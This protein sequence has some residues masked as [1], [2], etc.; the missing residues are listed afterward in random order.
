MKACVHR[1]TSGCDQVTL[2]IVSNKLHRLS[3]KL[4]DQCPQIYCE[5][6][7]ARSCIVNLQRSLQ[8]EN[9]SI[10]GSIAAAKQCIYQHAGYCDPSVGESLLREIPLLIGND[11]YLCE[12]TLPSCLQNFMMTAYQITNYMPMTNMS[13]DYVLTQMCNEATAAFYCINTHMTSFEGQRLD[14]MNSTQQQIG[15]IVYGK[16]QGPQLQCYS[17][18]NATSNEDCNQQRVQTCSP[19]MQMCGT[20]FTGTVLNK[21]CVKPDL[22]QNGCN[23]VLCSMCCGTSLC[24]QPW[25]DV[26]LESPTCQPEAAMYCG[27]QMISSLVQNETINCLHLQ[28]H[29]SCMIQSTQDCTSSQNMA[30]GIHA[31]DLLARDVMSTCLES[32]PV[33]GCGQ[34]SSMLLL[35][36]VA[37]PFGNVDGFCKTVL[38][39]YERTLK[40]MDLTNCSTG[41]IQSTA[42]NVQM[43]AYMI[44]GICY[45]D[46]IDNRTCNHGYMV[47]SH[48]ETFMADDGC[49]YCTCDRGN[50][51]CTLM[52][53]PPDHNQQCPDID[54]DQAGVC[55]EMCRADNDCYNGQIC[56]SNGCGHVCSDPK[57]QGTD[58]CKHGNSSF[59]TGDSFPASDGCNFCY[60]YNGMISC[61]EM[62]CPSVNESCWYNG[63]RYNNGDSFQADDGCN[64]C[65]CSKGNVACTLM[66]CPPVADD[67]DCLYNGAKYFS[68]DNFLAADGCNH[69]FCNNG[70]VS[71]TL[72]YCPKED[73][74]D[75]LGVQQCI[76]DASLPYLVSMATGSKSRH[77]CLS[78]VNLL[79][80]ADSKVKGCPTTV[81]EIAHNAVWWNIQSVQ[82]I[83]DVND[84]IWSFHNG[85]WQTNTTE[86]DTTGKCSIQNAVKCF[87]N[88]DETCDS[89]Q[90]MVDCVYDFST[91]CLSVDMVPVLFELERHLEEN[92]ADCDLVIPEQNVDPF[93]PIAQCLADFG[94][95]LNSELTVAYLQSGKLGRVCD[96]IATLIYCVHNITYTQPDGK[97]LTQNLIGMLSNIF[98]QCNELE[99]HIMEGIVSNL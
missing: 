68:G 65:F 8:Y 93:H 45:L 34:C 72:M 17:C 79:K 59:S 84:L 14:V 31:R 43:A 11:A 30:L 88:I 81:L 76:N 46:N 94:S 69:C 1:A 29:I 53:C 74:C 23:G 99:D 49:N 86:L 77:V 78:A 60:C 62:Y 15:K 18:V 41:H 22:C 6:C 40:E 36:V 71:C 85:G 25:N 44:Q 33:C 35:S 24:N 97:L 28:E 64:S 16:C 5:E 21:G 13:N 19:D 48:G 26:I 58:S 55:I 63:R 10:C 87:V 7:L 92:I 54:P 96:S 61:T 83:C 52:Y 90:T 38:E 67:K 32:S 2:G 50:I 66:L 75:V 20:V 37:S 95:T 82:Y 9:A 3:H 27:F 73:V 47:Y 89:Y 80:C 91:G 4:N 57:P 56:C 98:K 39:M 70:T 12:I 42:Y 51:G